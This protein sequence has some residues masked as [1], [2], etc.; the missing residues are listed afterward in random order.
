M[1]INIDPILKVKL[2]F[3]SSDYDFEVGGYLTG[4]VK[5]GQLSNWKKFRNE[6]DKK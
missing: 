6:Q 2:D 4:H 3:L 1:K 5:D